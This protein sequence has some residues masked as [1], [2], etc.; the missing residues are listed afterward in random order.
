MTIALWLALLLLGVGSVVP[1]GAAIDAELVM[2]PVAAADIV[3]GT[4]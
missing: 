2:L 3:A 4:V 1:V